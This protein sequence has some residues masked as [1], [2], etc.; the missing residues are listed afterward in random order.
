MSPLAFVLL[1]LLWLTATALEFGIACSVLAM[2]VIFFLGD[3]EAAHTNSWPRRWQIV[4]VRRSVWCTMTG[5]RISAF[6][7]AVAD[8]ANPRLLALARWVAE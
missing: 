2:R 4:R 8:Y 3:N 6:A 1:P 5:V 7:C